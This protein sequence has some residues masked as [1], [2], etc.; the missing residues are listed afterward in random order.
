M[1]IGLIHWLLAIRLLSDITSCYTESGSQKSSTER[2]W[3]STRTMPGQSWT[4]WRSTPSEVQRSNRSGEVPSVG[5]NDPPGMRSSSNTYCR[6]SHHNARIRQ[7][8]AEQDRET[9]TSLM[10]TLFLTNLESSLP[11]T[12]LFGGP[13]RLLA[14]LRR[15]HSEAIQRHGHDILR[16]RESLYVISV[17]PESLLTDSRKTIWTLY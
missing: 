15:R 8:D 3:G 16:H 12:H 6:D 5:W 11:A 9:N 10:K 13:P 7:C 17:I 1:L 4:L 14:T 2:A